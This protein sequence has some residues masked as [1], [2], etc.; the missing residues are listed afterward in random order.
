MKNEEGE[1]GR[2]KELIDVNGSSGKES[3]PIQLTYN[4]ITEDT[5]ALVPLTLTMV[6]CGKLTQ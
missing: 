5:V 4:N 1:E 6:D 2:C 3:R